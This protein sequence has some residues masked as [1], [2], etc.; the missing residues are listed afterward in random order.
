[1]TERKQT[2][3]QIKRS[4]LS[5]FM[6]N[7]GYETIPHYEFY[8]ELFP[9]GELA[10]WCD[11]PKEQN[12]AEWKYN[13]VII[14]FMNK[15]RMVPKRDPLTG[16]EYMV[17]RPVVKRHMVFDDLITIDR[18]IEQANKDGHF[19]CMA[20]I[21][22]LGRGRGKSRERFLYALVIE[23]D[24]LITEKVE[25]KRNKRQLGMETLLHQWGA[26]NTP[27][28]TKG[29][30][31]A[32]TAMVCSGSGVH[33]YWFFEVPYPLFGK[34]KIISYENKE[35]IYD[36]DDRQFQ[37][38]CFRKNFTKYI[39][40]KE[41]SASPPQF[42]YHGQ[43]FRV[44]GTTGKQGHLVEAF[45]ISK[46]RYTLEELFSQKGTVIGDRLEPAP[47]EAWLVGTKKDMNLAKDAERILTDKMLEMKEIDPQW[48]Q[49]VIIDRKPRKKKQKG[50][51][52]LHPNW[53]YQYKEM[54][55]TK[56]DVGC[57][58]SRLYT[59]AQM[60]VKCDIPFEQ[61]KADCL[62]IG[63][64]FKAISLQEP[65]KDWEINKAISVYFHPKARESTID[66]CNEKAWLN[67]KKNKRN[68]RK[69]AEHLQSKFIEDSNGKKVRNLCKLHRDTK[70][71]DMRANG[72]IP[73]RP[74]KQQQI[75]EWRKNNRHGTKADCNRETGIDPKTIRKWWD[76]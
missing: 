48:F 13:G 37:W 36:G 38:D 31:L 62:E 33:L 64:I 55:L 74:S 50:Q 47:K 27:K 60:G 45:W 8:R 3:K 17:E 9:Q 61:V 63:E 11:N 12:E 2:V 29:M 16:K 34:E 46:K 24:D 49:D 67:I 76:S 14:Q 43:A 69:R 54:I 73:G 72:E 75:Q 18:V 59:L 68:G 35:Y 30:Y 6:S 40:N 7:E 4:V 70:L 26:N 19:C 41:V 71:E 44:V 57:R 21:S 51:W 25:G 52:S 20:P 42:E 53:Y 1:M 23:I 65:L 39:W 32:P 58:Y 10:E 15:T 22:Y 66:Y 56:P 5:Q 28:W